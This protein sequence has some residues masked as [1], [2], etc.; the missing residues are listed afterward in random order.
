MIV[1]TSYKKMFDVFCMDCRVLPCYSN[2]EVLA[3]IMRIVKKIEKQCKVKVTIK[4]PHQESSKATDKNEPLVKAML[5]A[6]HQVYKNSPKVVGVGGG[7]VAASLRNVGYPAVVYAKLDETMH[8]PNEYVSIKNTLGDS[9]IFALIAY[10]F[11]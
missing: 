1:F 3:E 5:K 10:Q 11:K 9:K 2:K 6:V 8:Q 7:T 4:I